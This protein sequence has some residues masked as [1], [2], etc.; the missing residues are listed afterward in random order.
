MMIVRR[1]SL[2]LGVFLLLAS[3]LL[4]NL[5]F[6][7]AISVGD[8]AFIISLMLSFLFFKKPAALLYCTASLLIVIVSFFSIYMHGDVYPSFYRAAFYLVAL[9]VYAGMS[10]NY[11][12]LFSRMYIVFS[13]AVSAFLILRVIFFYAGINWFEFSTPW[14]T[15]EVDAVKLADIKNQGFRTG[16]FF[17]EPSYFV[18]YVTP[19][20]FLLAADKRLLS[21][22][23]IG[24]AC[25]LSTSSLGIAIFL[26]SIGY[27]IYKSVAVA[28]VSGI[29]LLFSV[30]PIAI[31]M[32]YLL[33]D[34]PGMDRFFVIFSS[35]GTLN[36]RFFPLLE[37]S[38]AV[39]GLLVDPVLHSEVS[40][41]N[42]AINWYNSLIYIL[43][44]F[45][46]LGVSFVFLL[47]LRLGFLGATV[48]LL[49]LSMTSLFSS[50]YIGVFFVGFYCVRLLF[51]NALEKSE[52]SN[53]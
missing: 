22:A 20:L 32:L 36:D 13:L 2:V 45:G 23:F 31:S 16:G 35:G 1:F 17:R 33:H 42:P 27:L 29:A 24:F 34:L 49:Y 41:A 28:A 10:A 6:W 14:P 7:G 44:M 43:G 53:V 3:P 12:F 8:L 46:L 21:L 4:T 30:V 37:I 25:V 39:T 50:S 40:N 19:A 38:A 48:L 18:I 26:L 51:L 5:V 52:A 9:A 15:Y 11:Y 47:S